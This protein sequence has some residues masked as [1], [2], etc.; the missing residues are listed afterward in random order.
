MATILMVPGFGG[1]GPGHWQDWWLRNDANAILVEQADWRRPTPEAWSEA[2]VDAVNTH[3]YA[4]LVAHSLGAT[5][6]TR[7]AAQRLELRIAGALLVAPADV[8]AMDIAGAEL[9]AFGPM[10]LAP[11]PFPATVVASRTDRCMRFRRARSLAT[12]WGASLV[13]Y[14]DAGHINKAAGYGPWPDGPRFLA[15]LQ[16]RRPG[17]QAV[18][19]RRP[20]AADAPRRQAR[21]G[22]IARL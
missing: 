8:E 17:P 21:P 19:H 16:N 22:A 9:R 5:L 18:V 3:P 7:I 6:V 11:L 12:A 13:D 20:E 4:W 15:S 14:G 1:S 2:L 10:S